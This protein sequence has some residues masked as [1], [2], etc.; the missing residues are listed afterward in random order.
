M[1]SHPVWFNQWTQVRSIWGFAAACRYIMSRSCQL[2]RLQF[3]FQNVWSSEN[4]MM[5]LVGIK[6][7]A[8]VPYWLLFT[9]L[10]IF[11][12]R[13]NLTEFVDLVDIQIWKKFSIQ[14]SCRHKANISGINF[15]LLGLINLFFCI[16]WVLLIMYIHTYILSR[17]TH[18]GGTG[19]RRREYKLK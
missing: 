4:M 10:F 13:F 15:N 6:L 5:N 7:L 3:S 12:H 1:T 18:E 2:E 9:Y 14:W 8:E 19:T 11:E 17:C 16:L